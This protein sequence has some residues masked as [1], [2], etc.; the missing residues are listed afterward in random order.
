MDPNNT[1]VNNR[2][3]TYM[4]WK[5]FGG[6]FRCSCCNYMPEFRGSI[7]KV[8]YCQNCG[9]KATAYE[10]YTNEDGKIVIEQYPMENADIN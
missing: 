1:L 8:K 3:R 4:I 5:A 9:A 6:S 7:T 10:A 2:G